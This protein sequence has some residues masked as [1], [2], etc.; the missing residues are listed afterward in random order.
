[1][2]GDEHGLTELQEIDDLLA[3]ASG[4]ELSGFAGIGL[5]VESLAH[6]RAT[7]LMQIRATPSGTS[8]RG[9][10]AKP[11]ELRPTRRQYDEP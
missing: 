8:T 3:R 4:D 11:G 9:S 2:A 5:M 10:A 6:R 1:M 7:I